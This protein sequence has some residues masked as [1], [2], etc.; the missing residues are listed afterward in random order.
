VMVGLPLSTWV[1]ALPGALGA[2]QHLAP[3]VH[4]DKSTN[5][6]PSTSPGT[7]YSDVVPGHTGAEC[8]CAGHLYL[9]LTRA[10]GNSPY[11]LLKFIW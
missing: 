8:C 2:A 1:R 9:A 11:Q 5:P 6:T 10:G 7:S 3:M 4:A